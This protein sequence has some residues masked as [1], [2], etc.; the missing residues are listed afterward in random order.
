GL[1]DELRT[2]WLVLDC[3]LLPWSAKAGD[4][5]RTQYA[6]VGA[7]AVATLRAE[8]AVLAAT[9]ARL[10]E[11]A[12]RADLARERLARAER[13]V[14]AYRRY[15]WPVDGLDGVKLAPFQVLAGE[16]TVHALSPHPWHL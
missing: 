3:E 9:A 13:F 6:P 5:L 14:D 8:E 10:D 4:L 16:A 11:A 12:P 15:C 1:W 7:A 2:D